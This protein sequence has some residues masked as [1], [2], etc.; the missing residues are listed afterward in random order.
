M[1]DSLCVKVFKT[2]N[3]WD[4]SIGDFFLAEGDGLVGPTALLEFS[5]QGGFALGVEE[6][7][8]IGDGSEEVG[9]GDIGAQLL[10]GWAFLVAV[11]VLGG[12]VDEED[13]LGLKLND[14]EFP[15]RQHLLR[16]IYYVYTFSINSY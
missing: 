5:R 10:S 14:G 6:A 3:D 16:E 13:V 2:L 15:M 7:V 12:S 11:E 8:I 1:Y 9:V 4:Y